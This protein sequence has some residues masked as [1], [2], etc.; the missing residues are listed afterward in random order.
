ML[1]GLIAEL[2]EAGNTKEGGIQ[3]ENAVVMPSYMKDDAQKALFNGAKLNDVLVFNPS[4]AYDGHE[5]EIASLLHIEKNLAA[6]VKADFS[7]QV[8]EITRF[9]EGEL[10][11]ELFDQVFGEGVVKNEEE[12]RAK[13]KESVAA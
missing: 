4:K 9:V 8:E 13:V 5:A 2:D 11:Q 7:F 12:F 10:S 3:V 1:K 6:D